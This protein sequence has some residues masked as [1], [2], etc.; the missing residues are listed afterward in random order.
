MR[1]IKAHDG[2]R[3][4]GMAVWCLSDVKFLVCRSFTPS[5]FPVCEAS[6]QQDVVQW[7]E[8]KFSHITSSYF[9]VVG[10]CQRYPEFEVGVGSLVIVSKV[11]DP[12]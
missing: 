1:T 9:V 3:E 12:Y 11:G 7:G 6:I 4:L 8:I 10:I 2:R 5:F